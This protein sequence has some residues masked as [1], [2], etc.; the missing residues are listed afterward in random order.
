MWGEGEEGEGRLSA[1][2]WAGGKEGD[3]TL[4]S[5]NCR[6]PHGRTAGEKREGKM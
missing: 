5:I 6:H 2:A 1:W 3:A 4:I